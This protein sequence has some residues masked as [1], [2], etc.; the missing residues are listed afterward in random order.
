MSFKFRQAVSCMSTVLIVSC[1]VF[2]FGKDFPAPV[3]KDVGTG[4]K[5]VTENGQTTVTY[6]DRQVFHGRTKGPVT[7]RSAN[8]NGVEYAAALDGDKILWENVPGAAARIKQ[9]DKAKPASA[10]E[11][12]ER[13]KKQVDAAPAADIRVTSEN[14]QTTVTY[15]G[16]QVFNGKTQ[17]KVS[18][19]A[20]NDNGVEH[21][22]AFDGE[23]VLWENVPGAAKQLNQ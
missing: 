4:I 11:M 15:K 17:D 14:G 10:E 13:L 18:A 3:L 2:A 12:L 22:A 9:I 7:A 5:V 20:R 21:A 19:Q 6:K 1:S 23:K 8:D 16:Q